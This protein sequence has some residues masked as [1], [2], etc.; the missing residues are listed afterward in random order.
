MARSKRQR[1]LRP[2]RVF[3]SKKARL[4]Q[5]TIFFRFVIIFFIL[6][7]SLIAISTYFLRY[8]LSLLSFEVPQ[9]EAKIQRLTSPPKRIRIDSAS[10]DLELRSARVFDSIWPTYDDAATHV[11]NSSQPL[12]GGNI[13]IF[14]AN[15]PGLFSTLDLVKIG[16]VI[17]ISTLD[18]K[19]YEY[20]VT[21]IKT[22]SPKDNSALLPTNSE[23]VTLFT[24][25][26]FLN[27]KRLVVRA[28][29]IRVPSF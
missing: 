6:I 12:D 27:S 29:P 25:S 24:N 22:V 26:G 9:L 14:A 5:T 13:L 23:I 18:K 8:K 28:T 16:D 3:K 10:I 20:L 11:A 19:S 1:A 2:T 15:K 7:V 17:T 4:Q 21:E